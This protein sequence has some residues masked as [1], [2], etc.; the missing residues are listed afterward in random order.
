MRILLV[1][2]SGTI[3]RA[4]EAELEGRHEVVSAGRHT[5]DV[6]LDIYD[7]ESI[8]AAFGELGPIDAVISATGAVQF[9][10]F[11]EMQAADYV[12]SLRNKLMGQVNLVLIGREHVRP[13]GSFTLTSG[14][15]D[16]DPIL[17]GT[18]ASMVNGGINAFVLAASIEMPAGQRINAVSPGVIE[19]AMDHY[20][21]YFRGFESVPARR[22]ALAYAKSVEGGRTGHVFR[23]R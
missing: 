12:M 11:A 16:E 19:E 5:G 18:A 23:V 2:A 21:P 3:G 9:A 13:A 8:R 14:V 22:A 6:R 1:G 17:G 10:P 4:V 7:S 15:L 20:A